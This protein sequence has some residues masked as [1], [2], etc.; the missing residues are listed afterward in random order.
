MPDSDH[1]SESRNE[2]LGALP[3]WDLSDLFAGPEAPELDA[4]LARC[5]REARDFHA[6]YEGQ[7]ARLDGAALGAA[8]AA[9]EA[10]QETLGR[11]GSYAQLLHAGD[12]SDPRIGRFYQTM[13]ERTTDISV[14]LLFFTLEINR[15]DEDLL[16]DRLGDPA[17]ARYGPWLR[18]QRAFRPHQLADDLERLLHEKYV[19][20]RA[21]WVRLFDETMAALRFPLDGADLT[22][23]EILNRLS[24]RDGAV[25]RAAAQSLAKEKAIEDSWRGFARPVSSRNLAN[26]V[27]DEVVDALSA[28]VREAYP[29]LA[30]RYYALKAK[31][32]GVETL[33]YWDRNAPLPEEDTRLIPWDEA[34]RTVLDAYAA[35][36]GT[37]A[38][39]GQQFFERPWID[40][41]ARPG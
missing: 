28:A 21:A 8:V 12:M 14:D 30:H 17:L 31:W 11:V 2:A 36:S 18:D 41:P 10:L 24:D 13:Q 38:E 1:P 22:S 33:P 15:L 4:A 20:G 26:F 29:R 9:Y 40:A 7:L 34:R 3:A 37:L 5:A 25:R 23:A 32:F 6:C 39:I 27:E 35:F 16:R 19:V